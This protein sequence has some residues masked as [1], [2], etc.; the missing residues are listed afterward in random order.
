MKGILLLI[1]ISLAASH[2]QHPLLPT[3]QGSVIQFKIR[4]LGL[5]VTGTFRGL[6]GTIGFDPSDLA[7]ARFEASVDAASINTGIALRNEHLR[8]KD[9]FDVKNYPRIQLVSTQIKSGSGEGEYLFYGTLT[10]KNVSRSVMF[11]FRAKKQGEGFIFEGQ[12]RLNRRD[13]GVGGSSLSL[14]DQLTVQLTVT[15]TK[16]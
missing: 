6:K 16:G 15:A 7:K 2:Q 12:F 11:P 5:S 1:L 4:N 3:D 9:Y 13:Y 14:S 10:I 8:G